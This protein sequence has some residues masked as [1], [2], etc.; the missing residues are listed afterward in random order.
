MDVSPVA[1][2]GIEPREL[3]A[4]GILA[5]R[6]HGPVTGVGRYLGNLLEIW[7][8]QIAA[9]RFPFRR[10]V[11]L[12][13][14][15]LDRFA[16]SPGIE[17]RRRE[18]GLSDA[19]WEQVHAPRLARGL[20]V[21]F[22]PSYS[23]PLRAPCPMVV[24]T[25]DMLQAT[26]AADFPLSARLLRGPLYRLSAR[27]AEA[28]VTLAEATVPEIVRRYGVDRARVHAIP[29]AADPRFTNAP[30]P[31]D[32]DI[33]RRHVRTEA[34]YVLF[35][36]KLA[37]RRHI[38]ELVEGF[39]RAVA[40]GS[41]PHRLVLVGPDSHGLFSGEAWLAG[42]KPRPTY[43]TSTSTR[44]D[45]AVVLT[46][47]VPD[48]DLPALY[49]RAD[50]VAY[51]SEDEGFGLP[52]VEAMRSGAPVLTLD[53]PVSREVAGDAAHYLEEAT[54]A[55]VDAALRLL[56]GEGSRR[57]A[58]V[59]AGLTRASRFDWSVTASRTLDV[60]TRTAARRAQHP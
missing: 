60:L 50:L 17:C 33:V 2:S 25:L 57:Q 16:E 19:A 7:A 53:R 5:Q 52:I 4:L 8:G 45:A 22:C 46:G 15:K 26:R 34:P 48:A 9:G 24:A 55:T 44:R 42:L 37:P 1:G 35:V 41:L 18:S 20:S 28:I 58:L 49:R 51:L 10:L 31:D 21:L 14:D 36:G 13:R 30:S 59:A 27:R 32:R 56:L 54:P 29:L 43:A 40:D 23:G 12:S 39:A 6:L 47:H 3:D 11:L 38:P